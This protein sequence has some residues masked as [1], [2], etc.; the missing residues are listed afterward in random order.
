MANLKDVRRL[1][2][3]LVEAQAACYEKLGLKSAPIDG[4]RYGECIEFCK[5]YIVAKHGGVNAAELALAGQMADER[6]AH[7]AAA[8]ADM[9]YKNLAESGE[10]TLP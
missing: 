10:K 2:D 9:I 3:D 5:G 8:A 6:N 4:K 7:I 1:S